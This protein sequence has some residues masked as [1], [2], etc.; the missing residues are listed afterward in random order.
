MDINILTGQ[1]VQQ[2][3]FNWISLWSIAVILIVHLHPRFSVQDDAVFHEV[4]Q[5]NLNIELTASVQ[6]HSSIDLVNSKLA[7]CKS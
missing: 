4:I 1:E 6:A 7:E 3:H 2:T 5:L